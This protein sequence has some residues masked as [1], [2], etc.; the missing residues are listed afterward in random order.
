MRVSAVV[1]YVGIFVIDEN[2]KIIEFKGF[3]KDPKKVAEKIIRAEKEEIEEIKELKSKYQIVKNEELENYIKNNLRDLAIK[4]ANF[5]NI[6]EF[7]SFITKVSIEISKIK[8]KESLRKDKIVANVSNAISEL[9]KTINVFCERLR[10]WYSIYFPELDK[11]IEDNE[12]FVKL[13]NKY[14]K[15]ENFEDEKIRN[16]A[17]ESVGI[18]LDEKDLEEIKKFSSLIVQMFEEKEKL[19]NYLSKLTA[20]IAP[21]LTE[22]A[23]PKIAAKLIEIAGSLEKLAKLP[24]TSIQ[25]MGAEKALFRFLKTRGKAKLPKHGVIFLHP[26]IQK[27]PK[28]L[29]GKIAR[30]LASKL[31]MAA[32]I[33]FFSGEDRR[34]ELKED[35]E[36]KIS[37]ILK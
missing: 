9:D 8:I 37:E 34:K 15:R 10:E 11:E 24:S 4:Y 27:A 20:E 29:R 31:S 14:L 35:L 33:D 19:E 30:I 7:H 32:K 5:E 23:T 2:K 17:K 1:T 21:N 28:E 13:V 12:K 6:V 26:Y 18:D 36:K 3:E 16:L 22:I 25:L